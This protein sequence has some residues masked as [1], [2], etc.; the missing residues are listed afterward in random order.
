MPENG[1]ASAT[2]RVVKVMVRLSSATLAWNTDCRLG[3]RPCVTYMV[4]NAHMPAAVTAARRSHSGGPSVVGI[5][6]IKA[7]E[8][9]LKE[10]LR[11]DWGR[12]AMT[13]RR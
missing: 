13:D 1:A 3:S 6:G 2:A 11:R 4:K 9:M 8:D 5:G 7:V 12:V 10:G